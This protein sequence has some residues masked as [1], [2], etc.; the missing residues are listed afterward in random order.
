MRNYFL[1]MSIYMFFLVPMLASAGGPAAPLRE[2][3]QKKSYTHSSSKPGEKNV[4]FEVSDDGELRTGV[5]WPDPRFTDNNDGTVTDNLTG[6]IWM[7]NANCFGKQTWMDALVDCAALTGAGSSCGL[8]DN[9]SEG[10]WRLPNV[11][12]LQSLIDY[13]NVSPA[14]PHGHPFTNV[15]KKHGYWTSTSYY[16]NAD[17]AWYVGMNNGYTFFGYKD[18]TTYVWPVRGGP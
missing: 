18:E 13:G 2:S 4:F 5:A 17:A 10:E 12:E 16:H 8:T 6:L 1:V 14:L 7:K 11:I 3:G 15:N 9:S